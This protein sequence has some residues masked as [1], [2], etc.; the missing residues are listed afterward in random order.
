MC[1]PHDQVLWWLSH[2]GALAHHRAIV[3]LAA[4]FAAMDRNRLPRARK[5]A[6]QI[7]SDLAR[8]GH[9]E[10]DGARYMPSPTTLV[11]PEPERSDATCLV[12]GARSPLLQARICKELGPCFETQKA[13]RSAELWR[14]RLD[15]AQFTLATKMIRRVSRFDPITILRTFPSLSAFPEALE[16]VQPPPLF[17]LEAWNPKSSVFEQDQSETIGVFREKAIGVRRWFLNDGK[18]WMQ[19]KQSEHR[20]CALW[21]MSGRNGLIEL[22]WKD[23]KLHVKPIFPNLPTL[24]ERALRLE[25]NERMALTDGCLLAEGVREGFFQELMRIVVG[26]KPK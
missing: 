17:N 2:R 12:Y 15:R 26:N 20:L 5:Q 23:R 16:E 4:H 21:W 3:L 13:Y 19:I 9:L 1:D 6:R 22:T 18:R 8:G 14:L 10:D 7:L 25:C 24:L 11:I